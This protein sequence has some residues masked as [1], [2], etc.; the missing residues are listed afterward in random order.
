ME[1]LNNNV[2]LLEYLTQQ[3]WMHI[4]FKCTGNIHK[5]DHV[6]DHK[7]NL[8]KFKIIRIIQSVFSVHKGIKQW[9]SDRKIPKYLEMKQT[10]SSNPWVKED[11][12][13]KN[14]KY[15]ELKENQRIAYQK[16]RKT[17]KALN[18]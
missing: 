11:V 12:S 2:N 7:A 9:I 10:N 4:L 8:N 3:Q 15:F 5:I 1:D 6:L 17:G 14:R 13:R 18:D 16:L